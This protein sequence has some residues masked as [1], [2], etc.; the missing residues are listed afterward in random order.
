MFF[1][2][3][4]ELATPL[5]MRSR[6]T[7]DGLLSAAVFNQTGKKGLET[8]DLIPLERE[9]GI[10]KGSSI[11][12]HPLYQPERVGLVMG[13]VRNE[14]DMHQRLFAPNG[15]G[16]KKYLP[17]DRTRSTGHKT[18]MDSY[19]GV[20]VREVYFWGDGDP[21]KCVFLIENF[22]HGIGKRA[23]T[24]AGQILRVTAD[25]T[26][27]DYSWVTESGRPARPLPMEVWKELGLDGV[28]AGEAV[29][30]LPYWDGE[31]VSAVSPSHLV[32][33]VN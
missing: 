14:A 29:V 18:T 28:P 3:T 27:E 32:E 23:N 4:L 25:E 17:I 13:F 20:S 9:R 22:I 1:K 5:Y 33:L 16:R 21:E 11:F 7:L 26:D 19:P 24:G 30:S 15:K 6:L 12:Y 2:L 8:V 10:F 31:K